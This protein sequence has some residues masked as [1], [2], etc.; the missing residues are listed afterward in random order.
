MKE[1][2]RRYAPLLLVLLAVCLAY[3]SHFHNSF[4]FDDMH[5][6]ANNPYIRDLRNIPKFFM[7]G[8]TFSVFPPNRTYRPIVSTTLALDYWLGKGY[9]LFYFHLS[10]FLFY[11]LQLVLMYFL[12]ERLYDAAVPDPR[13][14]WVALFATALYG[15][16]PAM[17]ETVNYIIQRADLYNALGVVAAI[18]VYAAK[19]R[20]RKYGIYLIPVAFAILSKAPALVFPAILFLYIWMFEEDASA[21]GLRR[22]AVRCLP[23]LVFTAALAAFTI[24]MTPK[25]FEVKALFPWAYRIT[26]PLVWLRYFRTFFLPGSLS[27][28]TDF[29]PIKS[30][31][32]HWAWVGFIFVGALVATVCL[33]AR[34]RELR[35]LA[36]GLSWFMLAL[37]PTSVY[38]LGEVEN[39]HR[40][41]SP[42][43]GLVVAAPWTVA[44]ILRN[45]PATRPILRF[46]VP[47]L[48]VLE[49]GAMFIGTVQRN[50]IWGTEQSLWHDVTIKSPMN[51]RGWLNYGNALLLGKKY[52]EAG[53]ALNRARE[54]SP[55][56][57]L[58]IL[59]LG[60]V[61]WKTGHLSEAEDYI[62][63]ALDKTVNDT[64]ALNIYA[65]LL[66]E[67][68]RYPEA[69]QQLQTA[70]SR[71]PD[72]LDAFYLAMVIHAKLH[73]WNAVRRLALNI[74]QR[75]PSETLPPAFLFMVARE[76]GTP[77]DSPETRRAKP[78]DYL[79]LSAIYIKVGDYPR[80]L[81]A[82]R[83][84]VK[85]NP[86]YPEAYNNMGV[87]YRALGDWDKAIEA[88]T[89][90]LQIR[91][92]FEA[93]RRNLVLA[94][95]KDPRTS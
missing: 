46:A 78:N 59:N 60:V 68:K 11:L 26:Q 20:W 48:C 2:V 88:C 56:H 75:F 6:V 69:L 12:F 30:V 4:H 34:K 29:A 13:N 47:M 80:A 33:A 1:F 87:A 27:A 3:A 63:R 19:P 71:N 54:L 65:E 62:K 49:L 14:R 32:T 9:N 23:A 76:T 81:G 50:V 41:F 39:D 38:V 95:R 24:R 31:W 52:D 55:N 22:A 18:L 7:D 5:T 79:E 83:D 84:A 40:M 89:H 86:S 36:F 74:Q 72:S 42:F 8:R 17:A 61:N 43:V 70:V 37:V 93:A 57:G 45:R 66:E 73:N 82:L 21:P 53:T 25:D 92:T 58:V 94:Q 15:L 67:Q 28:D 85:E 35:P 77:K 10:T 90:A 91:P 51:P 16:H 64:I 44:L